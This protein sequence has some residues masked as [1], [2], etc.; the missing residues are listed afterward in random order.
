MAE[1]YAKKFDYIS[2]AWYELKTNG[3]SS[4]EVTVSVI[5]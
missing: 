2:T 4:E 3:G 1:K 5:W